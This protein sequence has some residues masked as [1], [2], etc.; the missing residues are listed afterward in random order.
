MKSVK[1]SKMDLEKK[2]DQLKKRLASTINEEKL[3]DAAYWK[4]KKAFKLKKKFIESY[5]EQQV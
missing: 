4:K 5:I 3:C 2:I 1:F